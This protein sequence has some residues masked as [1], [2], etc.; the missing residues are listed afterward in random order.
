MVTSLLIFLITITLLSH[1][2][3]R[4]FI[5]ETGFFSVLWC[6]PAISLNQ[7]KTLL[8]PESKALSVPCVSVSALVSMG[9]SC[10]TC[11]RISGCVS[12]WPCSSS[13][14]A[15]EWLGT[16]DW[17]RRGEEG[18]PLSAVM[19][20]SAEFFLM[21]NCTLVAARVFLRSSWWGSATW[22]GCVIG[23]LPTSLDSFQQIHLGATAVKSF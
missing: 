16:C 19:W 18:P 17:V 11:A 1:L 12:G 20:A 2:V 15:G 6:T 23:F 22:L 5:T 13:A 8:L 7:V 9:E 10:L 3:P 4:P 21:W 14:G